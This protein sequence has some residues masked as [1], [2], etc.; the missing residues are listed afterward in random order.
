MSVARRQN[1]TLGARELDELMLESQA[2][3]YGDGIDQ[4]TATRTCGR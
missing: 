4:T 3:G 2:T 1:R